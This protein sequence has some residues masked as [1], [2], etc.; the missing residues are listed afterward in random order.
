[1]NQILIGAVEGSSYT[2]KDLVNLMRNAFE[3]SWLPRESKDRYILALNNYQV[4]R[5]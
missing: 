2:E 4:H 3:G 5:G 1:M